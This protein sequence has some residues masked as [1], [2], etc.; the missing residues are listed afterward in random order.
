MTVINVL[1]KINTEN[2]VI[3]LATVADAK[4]VR[5]YFLENYERFKSSSPAIDPA[6]WTLEYWLAR[7]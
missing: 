5:D 2:L 7:I 6:A 4:A 1:P 3:R